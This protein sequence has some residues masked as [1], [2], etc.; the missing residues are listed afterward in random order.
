[1]G[2]KSKSSEREVRPGRV[3]KPR[4]V[5]RS[6]EREEGPRQ[7]RGGE[8]RPG[9]V[10]IPREIRRSKEGA[11]GPGEGDG[12]G[13]DKYMQKMKIERSVQKLRK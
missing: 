6:R 5:R 11:N 13:G 10:V 4:E 7:R 1:M 12:R 8:I 3:E 9:R 2:R